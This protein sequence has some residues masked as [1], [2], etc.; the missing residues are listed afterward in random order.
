MVIAPHV[1]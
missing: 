1:S